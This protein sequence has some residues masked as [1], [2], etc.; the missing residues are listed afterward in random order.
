M[1]QF[2][3]EHKSL[4]REIKR[5]TGLINSSKQALSELTSQAA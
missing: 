4:D 5:I 1:K 3:Q 2:S